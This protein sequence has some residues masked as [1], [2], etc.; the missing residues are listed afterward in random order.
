MPTRPS[1]R[2]SSGELGSLDQRARLPGNQQVRGD[3]PVV[4]IT[5]TVGTRETA[6]ARPDRAGPE[7]EARVGDQRGLRA[8]V[9]ACGHLRTDADHPVDATHVEVAVLVERGIEIEKHYR[10]DARGARHQR[11]DRV[12]RPR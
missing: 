9:V 5:A 10:S 3:Q 1:A 12:H 2:R 8:Q 4:V 7:E 11:P 6:P